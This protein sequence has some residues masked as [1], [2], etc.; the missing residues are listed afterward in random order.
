[1]IFQ[2]IEL[3]NYG[4]Y[5]GRHE[6]D[7][8][9]SSNGTNRS[10]TLIGGLNGAGKTSILDAFRLVLYGSRAR[11]A[12]RGDL[13]Y[14]EF[15]RQSINHYVP[16]QKE[17]S[18]ELS[19]SYNAGGE[20]RNYK[21]RRWWSV[22]PTAV[23]ETLLVSRDGEPDHRL[24]SA[25]EEQVEE[26][27]PLGISNL[28]LFDGEQV[29][30]LAKQDTPT[31]EV[32][33]AIRSLL[34]FELID[35]LTRDIDVL[36]TRKRKEEA[37]PK[38]R[39]RIV[40]IEK[41]I[42][43]ETE[44]LKDGENKNQKLRE[45][46]NEATEE[47]KRAQ[48][49]FVSEGGELALAREEL[50]TC[51]R[52]ALV[53]I[54]MAEGQLRDLAAGISPLAVI[55]KLLGQV[56]QQVEEEIHLLTVGPFREAL[57][58]RDQRLLEELQKM[59]I[60]KSQVAKISFFL[61][62]DLLEQYDG[63]TN[64]KILFGA[65]SRV[66]GQIKEVLDV[67]LK[68]VRESIRSRKA[69]LFDAEAD[70]EG[71]EGKLVTS[72]TGEA[73][74]TLQEVLAISKGKVSALNC[75]IEESDNRIEELRRSIKRFTSEL[76]NL[77]EA[78]GEI[79]SK[80]SLRNRILRESPRIKETLKVYQDRLC[81]K[82][83]ALLE[84]KVTKHF[85]YL[86]RKENFITC[87]KI[88]AE[89]YCLSVFGIKGEEI[90]KNRLSAGEKQ[91]LAV[92]LLWGLADTSGRELPIVVD[93]PLGRLDSVHREHLVDRYFPNASH[94]VVVLSTDTEFDKKY[95]ARLRKTGTIAREYLLSFDNKK[96]ST[97]V[98]D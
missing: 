29:G 91:L 68:E 81:K 87:V 63:K 15:L 52:K 62:N 30:E 57:S 11:C 32:R 92:A 46:L 5:C 39:A 1:M 75:L 69:E 78:N 16:G 89:T 35:R 66:F 96:K 43:E 6:M 2:R 54:E 74:E 18:I 34:G 38:T 44:R 27:I 49:R 20:Q 56:C 9:P 42:G 23:N 25:W 12:S 28:F 61:R 41:K 10:I 31:P 65:D 47:E 7:L 13:P 97:A 33:A 4:P 53:R 58:C 86:I 48:E 51:K 17:A 59:G 98:Y 80:E 60:S 55:E 36:F 22:T 84:D 95:T 90:P 79:F 85:S 73:L 50:N 3:Y 8:S 40:E 70:A 26:I 72:A 82:R 94:Q 67:R 88:D 37:D 64:G 76:S 93:T 21:V 83:I 71:I 14:K 77:C 19:F 45:Q 24:T